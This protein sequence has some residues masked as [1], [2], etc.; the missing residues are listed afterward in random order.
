VFYKNIRCPSKTRPLVRVIFLSLVVY[1]FALGSSPLHGLEIHFTFLSCAAALATVT[2]SAPTESLRKIAT[3][4]AVDLLKFFRR[5]VLNRHEIT[6][7]HKPVRTDSQGS[8]AGQQSVAE[9]IRGIEFDVSQRKIL[10]EEGN[11]FG[12]HGNVFRGKKAINAYLEKRDKTENEMTNEVSPKVRKFLLQT[13][14]ES[15]FLGVGALAR[16]SSDAPAEQ[17]SQFGTLALTVVSA[18]L[19]RRVVGYVRAVDLHNGSFT[20]RVKGHL[21]P[22][23]KGDP[24]LWD[25]HSYD[26]VLD[27]DAFRGAANN[28]VNLLVEGVNSQMANP[29]TLA[30][31]K[32]DKTHVQVDE[33]LAFDSDG[34]PILTVVIRGHEKKPHY[35]RRAPEQI[36]NWMET[37]SKLFSPELEPVPALVPR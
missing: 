34:T 28:D 7:S 15:G 12:I 32:G 19:G 36:E 16:L 5:E 30:Q 9:R 37:F 20:N 29:F 8:Q 4:D 27:Q 23:A 33:L 26:V 18:D 1:L 10:D 3:Q 2:D 31:S 25:F 11:E 21:T 13:L 24:N 14:L 22:E 17:F 35:P 6:A